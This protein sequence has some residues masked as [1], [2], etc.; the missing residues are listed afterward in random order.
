MQIL[1]VF[2]TSASKSIFNLEYYVEKCKQIS[3]V[4]RNVVEVKKIVR[5]GDYL[6]GSVRILE[7]PPFFVW[8]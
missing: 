5:V 1:N 3:A 4:K 2:N 8:F 6:L 7:T